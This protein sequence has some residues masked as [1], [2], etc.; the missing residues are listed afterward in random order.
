MASV[1]QFLLNFTQR[2]FPLSSLNLQKFSLWI[3]PRKILAL[4]KRWD[5]IKLS[6]SV[7]Y[8]LSPIIRSCFPN[9]KNFTSRFFKNFDDDD[10]SESKIKNVKSKHQNFTSS[11]SSEVF[12]NFCEFIPQFI[13]FWENASSKFFKFLF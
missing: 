13:G 7:Q 12:A 11:Y 9:I 1:P 6:A 3:F 5:L 2:G 8:Y 4:L 10:F